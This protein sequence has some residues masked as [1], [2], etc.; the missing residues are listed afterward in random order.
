MTTTPCG[1]KFRVSLSV[2]EGEQ[3]SSLDPG[4]SLPSCPQPQTCWST[5]GKPPFFLL[6]CLPVGSACPAPLEGK[7]GPCHE[8]TNTGKTSAREGSPHLRPGQSFRHRGRP[9][10]KTSP[11]RGLGRRKYSAKRRARRPQRTGVDPEGSVGGWGSFQALLQHSLAL[12]QGTG[13]H[14][15]PHI[16]VLREEALE[17]GQQDLTAFFWKGDSSRSLQK[18]QRPVIGDAA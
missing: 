12:R 8:H 5:A 15:L 3:Q 10:S 13:L 18:K 14:G 9:G 1:R 16:P 17:V 6:T 7:E 4:T 2:L 11:R